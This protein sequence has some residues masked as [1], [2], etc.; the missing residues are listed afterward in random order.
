MEKVL[1]DEST[2]YGIAIIV[3][4]CCVI[5]LAWAVKV[6]WEDKKETEKKFM[7]VISEN[8]VAFQQLQSSISMLISIL[9]RK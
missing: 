1:M 5:G 2:K 7:E 8:T 3:L 4:C 6:M 9:G